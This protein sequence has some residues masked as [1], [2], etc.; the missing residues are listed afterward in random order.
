MND[1]A[2]HPVGPRGGAGAM[3]L[4]LLIW[5]FV[6]LAGLAVVIVLPMILVL[7]ALGDARPGLWSVYVWV[8]VI[9]LAALWSVVSGLQAMADP[10]PG[11]VA[12]LA[13]TALA[14]FLS[15]PPFWLAEA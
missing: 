4:R 6:L 12:L 15:F 14:A 8:A 3:A 2:P 9:F 5:L 13:G 1:G 10:R 11:R 7:T